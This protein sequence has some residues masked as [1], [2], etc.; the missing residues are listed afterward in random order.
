M[1][2]KIWAG[3]V[4]GI[5]L[6]SIATFAQDRPTVTAVQNSIYVGADGRYEANPDTALV[7]FNIGAQGDQIKPAYDRA[8]RAAEQVRQILKTNGIDV[9]DAEIGFFSV[10]PMYDWKNPKQKVVG[11][12]VSSSIK[13]KLRDFSKVGAMAE[14]FGD[15]DVTE[16]QS[17]SYILQDTEAAKTKAAED[18]FRR[19]KNEAAAVAETAGRQLGELSYASIDTTDIM[20]IR[21]MQASPMMAQARM[22][23]PM[24]APTA[25]FTPQTI[26][27]T[28]HVNAMFALR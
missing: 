13:V 25:D 2:R 7:Q 12:K 5:A 11:Y 20:P 15:M 19:A 3:I 6:F 14:A 26:Q 24:A 22:G 18:A 28:A 8:T 23:A 27:V 16:N 10:A 21:M 9:K 1:Y 4:S 17:I